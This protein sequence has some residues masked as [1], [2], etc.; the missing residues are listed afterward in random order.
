MNKIL[1]SNLTCMFKRKHLHCFFIL[2][3]AALVFSSYAETNNSADEQFAVFAEV[4]KE[5]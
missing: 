4:F 1:S 5:Y 3:F 2:A